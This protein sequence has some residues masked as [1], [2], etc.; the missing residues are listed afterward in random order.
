MLPEKESQESDRRITAISELNGQL[1]KA[2]NGLDKT[3]V[4][5]RIWQL[6]EEE[7]VPSR[8]V[9]LLKIFTRLILSFPLVADSLLGLRP[10]A[11]QCIQS[12]SL[13][14]LSPVT[15]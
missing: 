1:G 14:P 12:T 2:K 10:E 15:N 11:Q 13:L 6:T 9:L 3:R 7:G 5:N 8:R 4:V